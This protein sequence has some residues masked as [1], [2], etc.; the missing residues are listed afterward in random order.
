MAK[1]MIAAAAALA[2]AGLVGFATP[3]AADY[4]HRGGHYGGVTSSWNKGGWNKGGWNRGG[5]RSHRYD[6]WSRGRGFQQKFHRP[7][8]NYW[9]PS[10]RHWRPYDRHGRTRYWNAHR[11]W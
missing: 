4:K 6:G 2:L 1:G 10:H 5:H 9:R 8:Y 7:R 11:R 3:A